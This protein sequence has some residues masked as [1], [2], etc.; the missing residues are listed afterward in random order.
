L[1]KEYNKRAPKNSKINKH[2]ETVDALKNYLGL[3]L[4]KLFMYTNRY[5]HQD[6][7]K[8]QSYLKDNL[9]FNSRHSNYL[10]YHA[11]KECLVEL[12]PDLLIEYPEEDLNWIFADI[13]QMLV[14][15]EEV[16]LTYFTVEG[17]PLRNGVFN[18]SNVLEKTSSD[19]GNPAVS[20]ISYFHFFE[21]PVDDDT[22]RDAK[23][24]II[25]NDWL[26]Y[27]HIDVYSTKMD[28]KMHGSKKNKVLVE[29]RGFQRAL[30]PYMW[31]ISDPVLRTNMTH[32]TCNTLSNMY[33]NDITVL[34]IYNLRKLV[35]LYDAGPHPAGQPKKKLTKRSKK[36]KK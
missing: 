22:N 25:T 10:L 1:L 18:S 17:T 13:I 12:C 33:T 4:Y 7:T 26:E 5:L 2:N 23:N 34:S 27:S 11:M 15:N 32:G 9:T 16:L 36:L 20:L 24:I 30:L 35:E 21:D 8:V 19:Y 6:Q 28:I 3:I 29:F 31:R 14:V